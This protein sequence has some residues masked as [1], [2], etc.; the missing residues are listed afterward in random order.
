MRAM[1]DDG[2]RIDTTLLVERLKTSGQFEP[3]GGA[4]Y[5]AEV[6]QSVPTAANAVYYAEIVRDKATLRALIHASTEI[7]R[8]AYD[9]GDRRRA[10]C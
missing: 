10:R 8:D 3:V 9:E 6:L 7:L 1:H 2:R 4:A 5:L